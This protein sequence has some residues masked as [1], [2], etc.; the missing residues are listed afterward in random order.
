MSSRLKLPL[1][2]KR[3][4]CFIIIDNIRL[5]EQLLEQILEQNRYAQ[6]TLVAVAANLSSTLTN[7]ITYPSLGL[8]ENAENSGKYWEKT[9][10]ISASSNLPDISLVLPVVDY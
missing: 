10:K 9:G 2:K 7:F 4:I 8:E 5:A 3:G 6:L 1:T